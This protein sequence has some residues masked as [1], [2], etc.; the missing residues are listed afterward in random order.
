MAGLPELG[1]DAELAWDADEFPV[2]WRALRSRRGAA[3]LDALAKCQ[4]QQLQAGALFYGTFA[5]YKHPK[6]PD[7]GA[8]PIHAATGDDATGTIKTLR[9]LGLTSAEASMA[10]RKRPVQHLLGAA[11]RTPELDTAALDAANPLQL[12]KQQLQ[13]A[14]LRLKTLRAV[15]E[16]CDVERRMSQQSPGQTVDAQLDDDLEWSK[17]VLGEL[18]EECFTAAG[19]AAAGLAVDELEAA[20]VVP[21]QQQPAAA[22]AA[23][24]AA[25]PAHGALSRSS[26]VHLQQQAAA[27]VCMRAGTWHHWRWCHTAAG[28]CGS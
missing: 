14:R 10:H 21:A 25:A 27:R 8:Y 9:L 2:L 6:E 3:L 4:Q 20:V 26:G 23:A 16:L 11:Q 13:Q 7:Y 15:A 19:A 17:M 12:T 22:P 24:A 28:T 18:L 1:I 5:F